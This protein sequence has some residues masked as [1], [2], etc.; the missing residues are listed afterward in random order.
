[1]KSVYVITMWSGGK[2]A[3][4]WTSDA[5]PQLLEQGNGVHFIARET[6]LPVKIIGP[7]SVEEYESGK[8]E[9]EATLAA[10]RTEGDAERPRKIPRANISGEPFQP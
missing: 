10:S 9:L 6:K 8:E 4:K 7:I 3:K 5:P 1:M 2:P